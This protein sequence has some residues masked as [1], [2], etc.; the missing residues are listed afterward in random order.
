VVKN[1]ASLA[2]YV[3]DNSVKFGSEAFANCQF[4]GALGN[5]IDKAL[6][7]Y[8]WSLVFSFRIASD[9]LSIEKVVDRK[10]A[11]ALFDAFCDIDNEKFKKIPHDPYPEL[12]TSV[13]DAIDGINA[14]K[15]AE[16]FD[17]ASRFML[18]NLTCVSVLKEAEHRFLATNELSLAA[19]KFPE[20]RK[21]V[22][23]NM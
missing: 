9:F 21:I 11:E 6:L 14:A 4:R 2:A 16:A 12:F 1:A 5:E 13:G 3:K 22:D 7:W 23:E 17:A 15:G 20:L 18:K 10:A 19:L 8:F